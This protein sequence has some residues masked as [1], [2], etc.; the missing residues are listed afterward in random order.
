MSGSFSLSW[1]R[2][3][4][5][6][7]LLIAL[8]IFYLYIVTREEALSSIHASVPLL[9]ASCLGFFAYRWSRLRSAFA[10][11]GLTE[12]AFRS[13]PIPALL[14][15]PL[16]VAFWFMLTMLLVFAPVAWWVYHNWPR[17]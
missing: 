3:A 10:T 1:T 9:F 14:G 8:P 13:N 15:R 6:A 7:F 16:H 2:F 5:V 12:A 17:A 11:G 4:R